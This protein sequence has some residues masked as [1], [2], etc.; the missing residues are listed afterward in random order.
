MKKLLTFLLILCVFTANA[1]DYECATLDADSINTFTAVID[2]ATIDS[3]YTADA[4][5]DTASIDSAFIRA[6]VN[7]IMSS[8][9]ASFD[10][11]YARSVYILVAKIDTIYSDTI[12]VLNTYVLNITADSLY[13]TDSNLS[14][15]LWLKWNE[16][17][18]NDDTLNILVNNGSRAI[19]LSNNIKF[20]GYDFVCQIGNQADTLTLYENLTL[21]SG[22]NFTLQ[23]LNS[24]TVLEI[25]RYAT[26][27]FTN[28]DATPRN[29]SVVSNKIGDVFLEFS[30][31]F[32]VS[33]DFD[34]DCV[35]YG[36]NNTLILNER[37]VILDGNN[38]L[39]QALNQNDTLI[40]NTNVSL[41]QDLLTTS[42]VVHNQIEIDTIIQ[43][44]MI[45]FRE[46][47][48]LADDDSLF[49][50]DA[51]TLKGEMWVDGNAYTF[52]CDFHVDD[53]GVAFVFNEAEATN[54]D[55]ADTDTK[56]C[57]I[58]RGTRAVIKNRTGATKTI[59]YSIKYKQ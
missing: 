23:A 31:N 39:I 40:L 48:S 1:Q 11:L 22:Q 49:L 2:T 52:A 27:T 21:A 9:I 54:C 55:N 36:Q 5:I 44:G 59:C 30:Q 33:G 25:D 51:T 18:T 47:I 28:N 3:S 13:I 43:N 6:L 58:D 42:N 32:T 14:N 45:I 53:G 10:S 38:V 56:L 8:N 15:K 29:F 46:C 34:F 19:D 24:P 4:E 35:S 17:A 26:L 37:F 50:P 57:L 20:D 7:S 12:R 41:D 16:N